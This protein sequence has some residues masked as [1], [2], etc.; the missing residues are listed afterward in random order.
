M[1]ATSLYDDFSSDYDRFVN[2]PSRLAYEL[3]FIEQQLASVGA[4]RVLDTACGT[5]M[6]A[7]ALARAGYNVTGTDVSISMIERARQNAAAAGV[8][9]TLAVAGFGDIA[10][11][12]GSGFD[13]VLCL[14]NSLPHALTPA[15]LAAALADFRACLRSG[16]LLLIQNR[17]FDAVL[18]Q[19]ERWMGP[20]AYR[21]GDREWLFIRFYDFHDDGLLT[22]NVMTLRR[23]GDGDWQQQVSST[24]LWPQRRAELA[25]A[26]AAVGFADITSWGD[27]RGAPFAAATSPNLIISTRR[28]A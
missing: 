20:Q 17:N 23:Q 16:G 14:G 1:V 11:Q 22:F 13:A 19:R 18:A 9:V 28:T 4:H 21:E 8:Q 7:I 10:A 24:Q 25:R 2:W 26:L 5:G 3:P 15:A 12:V 6:H 27:M